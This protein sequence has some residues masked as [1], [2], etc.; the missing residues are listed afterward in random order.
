MERR[1]KII[2]GYIAYGKYGRNTVRKGKLEKEKTEFSKIIR[3]S[4]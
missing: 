4:R 2:R 3:V 1:N